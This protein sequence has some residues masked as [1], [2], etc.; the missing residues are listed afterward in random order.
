[1][2][3][4]AFAMACHCLLTNPKPYSLHRLHSLKRYTPDSMDMRCP[5]EA[6]PQR[7]EVDY[8]LPQDGGR[9]IGNDY[10]KQAGSF[11][12]GDGNILEVDTS[13]G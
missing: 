10:N 13:D 4:S 1:M 11:L 5:E 2:S 8:G 7:Q 3:S 9:E 12:L 6:K